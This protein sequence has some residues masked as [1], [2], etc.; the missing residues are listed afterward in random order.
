MTSTFMTSLFSFWHDITVFILTWHQCFPDMPSTFMTSAFFFR[1][2]I[3]ND[4]ITVFQTWNLHWWH[5]CFSNMTSTFMTSTLMTSVYFIHDIYIDDISVFQTCHLHYYI[6]VFQT[7]HLYLLHMVFFRYEI[8]VYYIGVS[9]TW[10]IHHDISVFQTWNI[11]LWH[12][13]ILHEIYIDDIS[14]FH[15]I[16]NENHFSYRWMTKTKNSFNNRT[17]TFLQLYKKWWQYHKWYFGPCELKQEALNV[18]LIC[19][20]PWVENSSSVHLLSKNTRSK[21]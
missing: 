19:Y 9:Q 5:Q 4:D 6:S 21:Y 3:Y 1:H 14:V 15:M 10:Y 12:Q 18:L 20:L 7:W 11:Y 8:Y 2:D 17:V 16:S 13:R